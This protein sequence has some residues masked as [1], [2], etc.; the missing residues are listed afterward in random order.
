MRNKS[1]SQIGEHQGEVMIP[2]NKWKPGDRVKTNA[3]IRTVNCVIPYSVAGTI[4]QV[5]DR[6]NLN[7]Q[8]LYDIIF[9]DG[10]R[11]TIQA[12]D[13]TDEKYKLPF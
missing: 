5:S 13:L 8:Y 12:F 7:G 9:D 11:A 1:N 10:Q 6:K 3:T 2:D 4:M